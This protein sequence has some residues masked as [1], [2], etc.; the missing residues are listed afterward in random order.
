MTVKLLMTWNI[1]PGREQEYFE[2][3]VRELIPGMQSLGMEPSDAWL[4]VYG[5]QPQILTAMQMPT[6]SALENALNTPKWDSLIRQ[7]T[8]FVEDYQHKIVKARSGFQ[9]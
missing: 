3:V 1:I 9:I 6:L 2:F 5:S 7:L 8:D 4:T